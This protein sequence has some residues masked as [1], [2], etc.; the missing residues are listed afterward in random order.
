[1]VV[2]H[3]GRVLASGPRDAVIAQAGTG[4]IREA[5]TRL[6][7]QADALSREGAAA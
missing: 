3:R 6:T 1:M 2:L 7:Q 5:F 4:D